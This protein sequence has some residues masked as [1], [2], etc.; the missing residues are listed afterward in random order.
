MA[1][2]VEVQRTRRGSVDA[3]DAEFETPEEARQWADTM[4]R[5]YGYR[6]AWIDGL[7]YEND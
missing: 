7:P 1:V 4:R 6:Q 3:E 2:K 5:H